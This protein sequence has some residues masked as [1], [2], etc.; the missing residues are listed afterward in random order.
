MN[1]DMWDFITEEELEWWLA[2]V[3]EEE[4]ECMLEPWYDDGYA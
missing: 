1:T 4:K 2:D 3:E